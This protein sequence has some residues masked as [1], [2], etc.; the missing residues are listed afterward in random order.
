MHGKHRIE[1]MREQL[2]AE[3]IG[4]IGFKGTPRNGNFLSVY[5]NYARFWLHAFRFPASAAGDQS[6]KLRHGRAY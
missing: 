5:Q 2:K 1:Q 3:Y 4:F 6:L